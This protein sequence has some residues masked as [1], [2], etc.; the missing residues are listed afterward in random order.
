MLP[1]FL[2]IVFAAVTGAAVAAWV[3]GAIPNVLGLGSAA[4]AGGLA[5]M[6]IGLVLNRVLN[7]GLLTMLSEP[8]PNFIVTIRKY[9]G[10]N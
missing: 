6:F 5:A 8:F 7:L 4:I 3:Y 2:S 9:T 1:S 10:G